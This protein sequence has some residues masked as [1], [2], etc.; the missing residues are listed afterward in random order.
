VEP[1]SIGEERRRKGE[2]SSD[3][4]VHRFT[5]R[6]FDAVAA[7]RNDGSRDVFGV[8][9][10]CDTVPDVPGLC[11]A[12][13]WADITLAGNMAWIEAHAVDPNRQQSTHP[14]WFAQHQPF[15]PGYTEWWLGD[16]YYTGQACRANDSDC[17]HWPDAVDNC[18]Y[19]FNP[20]QADS[21]DDGAGDACALCPC[22]PQND[23]DGDLVCGSCTIPPVANGYCNVTYC[24]TATFDNC[25]FV[26]NDQSNCNADAEG[27]RGAAVLGDA[28]DPVPCP[29]SSAP[30]STAIGPSCHG[31]QN[32]AFSCVGRRVQNTIHTQ[33]IGA[34]VAESL[35]EAS[36]KP[37][38]PQ[39]VQQAVVPSVTTD[40]RFCEAN[41]SLTPPFDCHATIVI[42]DD[43][44][45]FDVAGNA[46]HPWHRITLSG[47]SGRGGQ[48]TGDYGVAVNDQTWDYVGDN[49][50]WQST[51]PPLIPP[52]DPS[53]SGCADTTTFGS[54]TCLRGTFWSHANT[55]VGSTVDNVTVGTTTVQVGLHGSGLANHFLDLT[56][57]TPVRW[58]WAIAE[59][60][61]RFFPWMINPPDPWSPTP[62]PEPGLILGLVGK[63]GVYLLQN[64]NAALNISAGVSAGLTGELSDSS[65][66][67]TSPIEPGVRTG[68]LGLGVVGVAFTSAG[69]VLDTMLAQSGNLLAASEQELV[70]TPFSGGPA[71]PRNGFQAVLTRT[72]GALFVLG[73]VDPTTNQPL[74]DL[75]MQVTGQRWTRLLV[76]GYTPTTILAGTFSY[77][78]R[79]LWVLDHALDTSNIDQLRLMRIDPFAS[80]GATAQL[81]LQ[82]P[83]EP[84]ASGYFLT[85]DHDGSVLLTVASPSGSVTSR[86]TVGQ[87]PP[88][89]AIH[90]EPGLLAHAPVVDDRGYSFIV[91][92]SDRTLAIQRHTSITGSCCDASLFVPTLPAAAL[93]ATNGIALAART[94]VA[95]SGGGF[96]QLD[97]AGGT[98][99][100]GASAAVG[101][102]LSQGAITLSST[103]TVNGNAD[104]TGAIT[105][106]VG[107]RIT[108]ASAPFSSVTLPPIPAMDIV[109]PA[110]NQGDVDLEPGKV[111]TLVPGA[112]GN[113]AVKSRA[114]LHLNAGIYTFTS[115]DLEPQATLSLDQSAGGIT[116]DLQSSIIFRGTVVRSST[117]TAPFLI[118]YFGTQDAMVEA[119]F[120][121]TFFAPKANLVLG[122]TTPTTFTGQ[123]VANSIATR[124]DTLIVF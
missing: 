92:N 35:V 57:D 72:A 15:P 25:P 45:P 30:L 106:G 62:D 84:G 21:N 14:K 28:C 11:G 3:V 37:V 121:G 81:V 90:T 76:S 77:A 95:H 98:V 54:G 112:Y 29:N 27:A 20:D 114:T 16:V 113:V 34:H 89:T 52:A 101:N 82:E 111:R 93:Y 24:A 47:A 109:F 55:P 123:Y 56:T 43:Q 124:P 96:S 108:G 17:D 67:W 36:K 58:T 26:G 115:L 78:D 122:S 1:I 7:I 100:L 6:R 13:H 69:V 70:P 59:P 33:T 75:W 63:P 31:V 10:F 44:L 116:I 2:R 79:R 71:T 87:T 104:S 61:V 105:L 38:P 22:D 110:T 32:I 12:A 46:R 42:G 99:T 51:S 50:F 102:I 97:N 66:V 48:W 86:V 103:A 68:Q 73:G 41:S 80:L 65:L 5:S 40:S 120:V 118:G 4:Q 88:V 39:A 94:T 107:S 53:Y 19:V 49:K 60:L 83:A 119:G 18:P 9:S 74:H 91:K 8:T 64:G 85:V 23:I 117:A